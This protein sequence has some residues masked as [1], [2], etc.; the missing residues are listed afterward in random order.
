MWG[1]SSWRTDRSDEPEERRPRR[2]RDTFVTVAPCNLFVM[3]FPDGH[4]LLDL[5]IVSGLI[6]GNLLETSNP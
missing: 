3:N 5:T 4:E 2:Q 6:G 1:I